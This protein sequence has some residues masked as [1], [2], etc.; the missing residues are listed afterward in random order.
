MAIK[1]IASSS[2]PDEIILPQENAKDKEN[3]FFFLFKRI[4]MDK[5]PYLHHT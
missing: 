1:I 2:V 4:R 3:P 5:L